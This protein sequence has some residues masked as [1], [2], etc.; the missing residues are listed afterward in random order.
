M[1]T[2]STFFVRRYRAARSE[3]DREAIRAAAQVA[4]EQATRGRGDVRSTFMLKWATEHGHRPSTP[5]ERREANAEFGEYY[6][7]LLRLRWE[8]NYLTIA[9]SDARAALNAANG[10]LAQ[11]LVALGRRKPEDDWAVGM[12]PEGY[13]ANVMV[14]FLGG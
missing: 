10:P 13:V 8:I 14:P 5:Q 12:S 11:V 7:R 3:R 6:F 9:E 2:Y 1:Q 4:R